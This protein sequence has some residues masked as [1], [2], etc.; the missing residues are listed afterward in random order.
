MS[1]VNLLKSWLDF[2]I[3]NVNLE[4]CINYRTFWEVHSFNLI[5]N[6]TFLTLETYTRFSQCVLQVTKLVPKTILSVY[7]CIYKP[8]I[9]LHNITGAKQVLWTIFTP[10][11]NY[12]WYGS[13]KLK[14]LCF[15]ILKVTWM[16]TMKKKIIYLFLLSCNTIQKKVKQQQQI[17]LTKSKF[18]MTW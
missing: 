3:I 9:V 7:T 5:F 16:R 15:I 10:F 4:A 2:N 11:N 13:N 18:L 1:Q 14:L 8:L 6:K 17:C 12:Y